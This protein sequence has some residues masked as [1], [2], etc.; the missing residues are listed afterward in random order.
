[1][2][3][4]K[5]S[6]LRDFG[7]V[8]RFIGVLVLSFIVA[9]IFI[10]PGKA[11]AQEVP[12]ASDT[13]PTIQI[14]QKEL[15]RPIA[16]PLSPLDE[17]VFTAPL[18][19]EQRQQLQA[20]IVDFLIHVVMPPPGSGLTVRVGAVPA[21]N[22]FGS[23]SWGPHIEFGQFLLR[24][25]GPCAG[26]LSPGLNPVAYRPLCAGLYMARDAMVSSF[27]SWQGVENPG[28]PFM[29]ELGNRLHAPLVVLGDGVTR[30]SL[31]NINFSFTSTDGSLDYIGDLAGT[32]CNGT[33]R[34]C[35]DYGP[36]RVIGTPDDIVMTNNE[37]DTTQMDAVFYNGVG[38]GWWPGGPGDPLTGQAA[39]DAVIQYM[40]DNNV[41]IE[42]DYAVFQY[43]GG[44]VLLPSIFNA[45]FETGDTSEWSSTN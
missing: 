45:G 38:T 19:A 41:H 16:A 29:S 11:A 36:D 13:D 33:T 32:T 20:Q 23:P 7:G 12:S 1:M 14:F 44:I 8:A 25:F 22:A 10:L 21:P 18:S 27:I 5:T 30:F 17:E 24:Y 3:S 31:S 39:I 15:G 9:A 6:H 43:A 28:A 37:P 4:Y 2:Q 35:L 40:L 26:I 34:V 42:V